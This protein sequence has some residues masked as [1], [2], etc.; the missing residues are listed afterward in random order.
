[1]IQACEAIAEAHAAGIVHRDLKPANLFE[2]RGAGED[3]GPIKVLD[4]GIAKVLDAGGGTTR[5]QAVMGSATYM[6]PEQ[7]RSTKH[8]DGRTDLWSLGATLYEL[9]TGRHPFEG[10]S[11]TE[12]IVAITCDPPVSPRTRRPELPPALEAVVL[13][14]LEKD[15]ARRFQTA[16]DL[17]VALADFAGEADRSLAAALQARCAAGA[18]VP[19]RAFDHGPATLEGEGLASPGVGLSTVASFGVSRRDLRPAEAP[20]S[21]HKLALG[22]ASLLLVALLGVGFSSRPAPAPVAAG[23]AALAV[24]ESPE[25]VTQ[26]PPS[27]AP[28]PPGVTSAELPP[29]IPVIPVTSAAVPAVPA[30]SVRKVPAGRPAPVPPSPPGNAPLPSNPS[31]LGSSVD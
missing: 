23:S 3:R 25:V 2:L 16:A 11:L 6:S 27:A 9:L 24:R 15:P 7:L 22:L 14:C 1:V 20:R 28:S 30:A 13:R 12:L 29:V 5:T 19:V 4:F 10:E 17:A 18:G 31:K 26:V 21:R 8:V